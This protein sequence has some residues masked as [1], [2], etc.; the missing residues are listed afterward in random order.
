M[1]TSLC[2]ILKVHAVK[3]FHNNFLVLSI[4]ANINDIIKFLS[5]QLGDKQPV[6]C[7]CVVSNQLL[8]YMQSNFF[9]KCLFSTKAKTMTRP[10]DV[11]WH[12]DFLGEGS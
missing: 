2:I 6:V 1:T 11:I 7:T 10:L 12:R 4:S 9:Y 3:G 8:V 5:Y